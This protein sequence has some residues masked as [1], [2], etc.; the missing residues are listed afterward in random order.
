[1][2]V[3]E[4][5]TT[6]WEAEHLMLPIYC[7][8]GSLRLIDQRALPFEY[9]EVEIESVERLCRAI[10]AMEIRGSGA[11]GIAGAY[12]MYLACRLRPDFQH[13]QQVANLLKETRPTAINLSKTV[14]EILVR[15]QTA[16]RSI[17]EAV[18][19]AVLEI[20][21]R[22]LAFERALGSYGAAL[23]NDGDAI[24]THCHSG[25]LAGSGYGGRALSVIR[26]AWEGG[27]NIH[28]YVSETRPYLQGARITTYELGKLGIPHTLITDSSSAFLMSRGSIQ[29][30]VVGSDRVTANGDLINKVGSFMH[31]IV[32]KYHAVPFYTATSSHTVDFS[33][34]EGK[35]CPIEYRNEDE[36]KS[37]RGVRLAPEGTAALYPAFDVTPN[38]LIAGI[39]TEKGVITA[40][41][42][43]NLQVLKD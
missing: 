1:M 43:E 26:A 7:K 4:T 33:L 25:A 3:L 16:K 29:R 18:E 8:G 10:Q 11:I 5:R 39:I 35:E 6:Q 22:Q 2:D 23:I 9:V 24:L 40:P 41:Y 21:D 31:A 32:A 17:P 30:V 12:G 20:L 36:V 14:D 34:A 38:D 28:V 15:C 42:R 37:I 27:K 19:E 13:L